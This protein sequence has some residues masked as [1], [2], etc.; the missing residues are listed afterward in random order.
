MDKFWILEMIKY[1][2]LSGDSKQKNKNKTNITQQ[3]VVPK[4]EGWVSDLWYIPPQFYQFFDDAL[5]LYQ[6]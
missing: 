3:K 5:Y 2:S 1:F 6:L 4:R